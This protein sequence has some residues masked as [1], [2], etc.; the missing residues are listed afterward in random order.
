MPDQPIRI[1]CTGVYRRPDGKV[2][3][4]TEGGKETV[5]AGVVVAKKTTE[6]RNHD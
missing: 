1:K 4:V 5:W 6:G 2:V 3:T